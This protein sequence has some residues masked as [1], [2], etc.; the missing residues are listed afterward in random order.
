MANPVPAAQMVYDHVGRALLGGFAGIS[1]VVPANVTYNT[2]YT[3]TFSHTLPIG[4]DQNEIELVA[5][6]IDNATGKI[7]NATKVDLN[8]VLSAQNFSNDSGFKMY[9]NP[10]NGLVNFNTTLIS[11]LTISDVSGKVVFTKQQLLGENEINLSHLQSGIYFVKLKSD[12][13]ESTAKLI[14]K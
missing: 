4:Q 14:L 2:P 12:S 13:T 9:P 5:L 6:V 1:G 3:T 11:D 10:S 8:T 7:V